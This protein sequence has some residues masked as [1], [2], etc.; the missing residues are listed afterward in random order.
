VLAAQRGQA[1][2]R[3]QLVESF[4]PLIVSVARA[5]QRSTRVCR[6]ELIQEGV[7][8][9]LRALQRYEPGRGV[10]F[11]AYAVWWVRQ[12]MQEVVSELSGPFVLSDRA[13]RQLARIK[14]AQRNVEQ[15]RGRAANVRELAAAAGLS[16][17]QVEGL[18]NAELRPQSLDEPGNT[19]HADSPSVSEQLHDPSAEDAFSRAT[20]RAL[21]GELPRL[22]ARLTERERTVIC[23]RYGIGHREQT[24]REV[25]VRLGVT[26][27]RVRQIEHASLTKLCAAADAR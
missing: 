16:Q 13:L 12:A 8:G 15:A 22:L 4:L 2:P 3:D 19:H 20:Y 17:T 9:L 18:I 26:A 21:A 7:V 14:S 11:W 23:S 6:D 1:E 5:Y 27:E 10:P 25:A 24:L